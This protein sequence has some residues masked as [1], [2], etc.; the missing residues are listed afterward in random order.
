[1]EVDVSLSNFN[2]FGKAFTSDHRFDRFKD[3]IRALL[4][5]HRGS[6]DSTRNAELGQPVSPTL[7][8]DGNSDNIKDDEIHRVVLP[9]SPQPVDPAWFKD[10]GLN[11]SA[12][13]PLPPESNPYARDDELDISAP[14]SLNQETP[15]SVSDNKLDL[16]A[17][18]TPPQETSRQVKNE[19][20]DSLDDGSLEFEYKV[21]FAND[22]MSALVDTL[23]ECVEH[24]AGSR[25][26]W[27]P[28]ANPEHTLH[29]D[30]VRVYSIISVCQ[31]YIA[32]CTSFT[33]N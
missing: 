13:P 10:D 33:E 2:E 29:V 3:G 4:V 14:P 12:S 5:I 15:V 17:S 11:P 9:T 20:S 24:I 7:S 18:P 22:L 8:Q 30:H 26:S 25:L 6:R 21:S 32:C 28:L 23:K 27:W 1:M 16:L 19:E 31:S